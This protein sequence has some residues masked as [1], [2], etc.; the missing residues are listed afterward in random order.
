MISSKFPMLD[1]RLLATHSVFN[2]FHKVF[3][4]GWLVGWMAG[5]LAACVSF[6]SKS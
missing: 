4:G 1:D 3:N 6:R 5:L 2:G